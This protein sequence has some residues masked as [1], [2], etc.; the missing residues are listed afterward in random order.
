M[1]DVNVCAPLSSR[2]TPEA[3]GRLL[4]ETVKIGTRLHL[5]W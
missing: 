5:P 2:N 1:L 4:K 3:V